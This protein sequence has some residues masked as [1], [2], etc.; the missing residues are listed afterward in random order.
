MAVLVLSLPVLAMDE[1][2]GSLVLTNLAPGIDGILLFVDVTATTR[3]AVFG[4]DNRKLTR[5]RRL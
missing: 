2:L 4:F 1:E 5:E 3:S